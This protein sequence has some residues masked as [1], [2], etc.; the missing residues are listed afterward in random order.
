LNQDDENELFKLLD[1]QETEGAKTFLEQKRASGYDIGPALGSVF[2]KGDESYDRGDYR[3]AVQY[4]TISADLGDPKA[5]GT[6]GYM[7]S[8]GKGV[9]LSKE[10]AVALWK[11][12]AAAGDAGGLANLGMAIE[13][14]WPG[15]EKSIEKAIELYRK[16]AAGRPGSAEGR[17]AEQRLTALGASTAIERTAS[18]AFEWDESVPH[19]VRT[20]SSF[21]LNG[22]ETHS[23]SVSDTSIT[24]LG[25]PPNPGLNLLEVS[26]NAKDTFFLWREERRLI[27]FERPYKDSAAIIVAIDDYDRRKDLRRRGPTGFGQLGSMR[28]GAEQLK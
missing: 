28:T 16:A 24:F 19:S 4:Y 5:Q 17:F 22:I 3:R 26:K 13:A 8:N 27:A 20:Q 6:L 14:G 12:S 7:Y 11:L 23:E 9:L 1:K 10:K 18:S 15:V 25:Q 2:G 21:F